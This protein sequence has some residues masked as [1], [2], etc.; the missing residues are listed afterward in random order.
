MKE[1][2]YYEFNNYYYVPDDRNAN[3]GWT[4]RTMY[5]G[6]TTLSGNGDG[7]YEVSGKIEDITDKPQ[8]QNYANNLVET[9]SQKSKELITGDYLMA[10]I[11]TIKNIKNHKVGEIGPNITFT[12]GL[13]EILNPDNI[14]ENALMAG[15][16]IKK[17][18]I[19]SRLLHE[20]KLDELSGVKTRPYIGAIT[21]TDD[22]FNRKR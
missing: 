17:H 9:I 20:E 5:K 8:Q 7:E 3:D 2:D 19:Y 15:G 1:P 18:Y 21:V 14:R 10:I 6:T 22:F 11:P 12:Y 4:Y 16:Y 13:R